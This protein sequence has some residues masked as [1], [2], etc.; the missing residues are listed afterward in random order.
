MNIMTDNDVG[1]ET[2]VQELEKII[3]NII[4]RTR[5]LSSLKCNK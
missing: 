5:Q 3:T 4:S 1:H 2:L